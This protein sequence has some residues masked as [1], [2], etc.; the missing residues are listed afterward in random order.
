MI[1]HWAVGRA[2]IDSLLG[3]GHLQKVRPDRDLAGL[4]LG[5]ARLHLVASRHTIDI[6]PTGS[7]QLAYDASRKA[8]TAMLENQG[9]RPTAKGGHR[10]VEVALRAQLVPPLAQEMRTFGWMRRLRNASEYPS[11]AQPTADRSDALKAQSSAQ[12]LIALSL[13]LLEE[14]PPY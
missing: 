2:D 3:Q 1:D 4:Y 7:F 5:Q 13:R 12:H 6:D 9:L 10:A 11:F 8:L 14:M